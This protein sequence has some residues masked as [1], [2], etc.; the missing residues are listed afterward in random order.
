MKNNKEFWNNYNKN[1]LNKLDNLIN[2]KSAKNEDYILADFH[3]HSNYSSDGAQ[4][5]SEIIENSKSKGLEVIS[6]TDH[7]DVRVYDEIFSL[8]ENGKL[9]EDIII[10]PG[11]EHTVSFPKYGTMCHILKHFLCPK[12]ESLLRD[13]KIVNDSYFNR[14]KIQINRI[15]E[16]SVLKKII[17]ENEILISYDDYLNF[18]GKKGISVP[19]Y[20]PLVDYLAEKLLEKNI[21]FRKLFEDLIKE[22]E[23]D[24]SEV[25]KNMKRERFKKL[26]TKYADID[27]QGNRRFLLSILAVRGVDDFKFSGYPSSGSL[28]VD[29]YGQVDIFKLNHSG[30]TSFAHPT[31]SSIFA[32][33]DCKSIGG[34]LVGIEDNFKNPYKNKDLFFDMKNKMNLVLIKGS[35]VHSL[36]ENVYENIDFYK[37]DL[38]EIKRYVLEAKKIYDWFTYSLKF[39]WWN[40][41]S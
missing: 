16:N 11:I 34:K 28:S 13:I 25:R 20:A 22:N 5:L 18:L 41:L 12:D 14:A 21:S 27:V 9:P 8:I 32:L 30:I 3:I 31:E 10:I 35:D 23:N 24:L 37:N 15:F 19:D 4:T 29:E 36:K 6:V 2:E 33:E 1:C 38:T 26:Q 40:A 39:V 17:D 7:D